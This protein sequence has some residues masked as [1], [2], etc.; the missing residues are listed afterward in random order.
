MRSDDPHSDGTIWASALWA[1]RVQ[2]QRQGVAAEEFDRMVL[3]ALVRI[4]RSREDLPRQDE[5]E[6]RRQF[7]HGLQALLDED[8]TP[9]GRIGAVAERVLAGRG[10]VTGRDNDQLRERSRAGIPLTAGSRR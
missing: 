8:R 5:L 3:R 2:L 4:G 7:G 9:G 6:H 1:T 10:I